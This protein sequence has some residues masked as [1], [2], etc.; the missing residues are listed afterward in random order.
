MQIPVSRS[1]SAMAFAHEV[2]HNLGARHDESVACPTGFI[3]STSGS[4]QDQPHFSKCSIRD[5]T[6]E[7]G[8][9]INIIEQ[10]AYK[11]S[12][13]HLKLCSFKITLM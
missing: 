5:M 6:G 3:M 2:G 13:L 12:N 9:R 1:E 10:M 8:N 11:L 4:N 7:G